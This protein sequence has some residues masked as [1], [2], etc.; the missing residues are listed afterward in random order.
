MVTGISVVIPNFNGT[1]L[2]PHTLPT[3]VQ[4]LALSLKPAE[5]IIVDDCSTDGSVPYLVQNYPSIKIL[6]TSENSGFSIAVNIG[7][8]ATRYDKVLVLNSDV[9][10]TPTYFLHQFKYFDEPHTF[11]VMGRITGWDD[12]KIQDGAKYPSLQGAKIKTAVNY[13]LKDTKAM[14][15]GLYSMYLSGANAFIDKEKFLAIGGLNE[16][17]SP[18]Y[19]EDYELSLRA[20]RLGF[21]CY[22]DYNSVCK[23]KTS[24]TIKNKSRK[25]FVDIIYNRN[26]M[27]LHA[28][29]LEGSAKMWWYLQLF[30]EAFLKAVI[31]KWDY[32]RSMKLFFNYSKQI[33]QS[34]LRFHEIALEYGTKKS[35]REVAEF[36]W[37]S[38]SE[39]E[40]IYL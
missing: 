22:Y 32:L 36:I 13:L 37:T 29:H 31:F 17:F 24:T 38:V 11:G 34:R 20:W 18:F 30:L 35:V 9:Q 28:L 26:K 16:L 5:I 15:K 4:A 25:K 10:L 1:H 23:H 39:K 19:V 3:V 14:D 2:F 6:S 8:A 21:K 27:L 33:K 7:V 12:A 40:K